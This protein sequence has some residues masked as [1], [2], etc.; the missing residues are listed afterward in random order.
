VYDIIPENLFVSEEPV[1]GK[2]V[3]HEKTDQKSEL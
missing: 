2:E 3:D 1:A